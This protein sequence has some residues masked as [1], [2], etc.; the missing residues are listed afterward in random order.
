MKVI[1]FVVVLFIGCSSAELNPAKRSLTCSGKNT[2]STEFSF[3]M[4]ELFCFLVLSFGTC[5][6]SLGFPKQLSGRLYM[7]SLTMYHYQKILLKS[8]FL[9]PAL[10]FYRLSNKQQLT[11]KPP[12]AVSVL[13]VAASTR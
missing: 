8:Y 10:L 1:Y 2:H 3:S 11:A 7:V 9:I 6:L 12:S 5:F 4:H 13:L